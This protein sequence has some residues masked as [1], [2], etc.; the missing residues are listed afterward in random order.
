L[1]LLVVQL[2]S[3]NQLVEILLVCFSNLLFSLRYFRV[4][5]YREVCVIDVIWFNKCTF[6][7]IDTRMQWFL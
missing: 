5:I 1:L 2:A 3:R 7:L 6:D 4:W